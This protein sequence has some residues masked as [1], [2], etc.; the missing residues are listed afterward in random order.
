MYLA[1]VLGVI[2]VEIQFVVLFSIFLLEELIETEII[3]LLVVLF[4]FLRK[5]EMETFEL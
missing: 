5:E 4:N 1:A 2:L 3:T